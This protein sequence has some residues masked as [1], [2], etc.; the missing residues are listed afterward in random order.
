MTS[1]NFSKSV[2]TAQRRITSSWVTLWIVDSI[3]SRPSSYCWHWRCVT[4]IGSRLSVEIMK[5]DRS[6]K[7]MD[8]MTSVSE[9]T[10]QSMSG[11]T[12][13]RSLTSFRW[14]QLLMTRYSVCMVA[15]VLASTHLM[16]SRQLIG[17]RKCPMTE[18]CVI[19]CGVI[20]RKSQVGAWV[21]EVQDSYLVVTLWRN[22]A[23]QTT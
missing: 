6:H 13:Q 9:S 19:W 8:S 3:R 5:A 21:R 22:F 12:A 4:K 15:W 17:S 20:Q 2:V 7:C 14:Q 11:V 10:D 23:I 16:R 1:W 18:Q